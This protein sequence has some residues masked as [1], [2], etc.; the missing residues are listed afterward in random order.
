MPTYC[1]FCWCFFFLCHRSEQS[2]TFPLSPTIVVQRLC[3]CELKARRCTPR[4]EHTWV[5]F[6]CL[7][8]GSRGQGCVGPGFRFPPQHQQSPRMNMWNI[9]AWKE[10]F[11]RWGRDGPFA[12][13]LSLSSAAGKMSAD[14]EQHSTVVALTSLLCLITAD[15][16]FYARQ[17]C[18]APASTLP[19]NINLFLAGA[20]AET[21]NVL[22]ARKPLSNP[23]LEGGWTTT[24]VNG[25]AFWR[26]V[27][28]GVYVYSTYKYISEVTR[29]YSAL[30]W[31]H[32]YTVRLPCTAGGFGLT[33]VEQ[34]MEHVDA[35][36]WFSHLHLI[37]LT[38]VLIGRVEHIERKASDLL[39][40][41]SISHLNGWGNTV[42]YWIIETLSRKPL[43]GW[44][45]QKRHLW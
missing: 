31:E 6:V 9:P 20:G 28:I 4:S 30:G 11:R 8:Y 3:V 19:A 13:K 25:V 45:I 36:G 26:T 43:L 5:I 27:I 23:R 42:S 21:R 18:F 7:V 1:P 22:T 29:N 15:G 41:K 12:I 37:K 39:L 2:N 44:I 38:N 16:S 10:P 35:G 32:N 33:E 34:G 40:L 24:T 14:T 17:R